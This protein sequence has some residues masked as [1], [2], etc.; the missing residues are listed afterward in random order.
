MIDWSNDD[1]PQSVD[2]IRILYRGRFVDNEFTLKRNFLHYPRLKMFLKELQSIE[3][4]T[5][6]EPILVMHLIIRPKFMDEF[7]DGVKGSK[8]RKG[9]DQSIL[10]RGCTIS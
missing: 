3:E 9:Y 1:R 4:D 10:C 5:L 7:D 6:E 8:K 2:A